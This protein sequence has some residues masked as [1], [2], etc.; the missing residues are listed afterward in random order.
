MRI[1]EIGSFSDMTVDVVTMSGSFAFASTI[2][3][4]YDCNAEGQTD[5]LLTLFYNV[6]LGY[7]FTSISK[8]GS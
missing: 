1:V 8:F 7:S 3:D 5:E 6:I 2:A 4:E